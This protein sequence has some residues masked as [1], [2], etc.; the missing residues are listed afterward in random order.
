MNIDPAATYETCARAAKA[1]LAA[2]YPQGEAA[3]MVRIIFEQ[4][5][6]YSP[7][8]MIVNGQKPVS[9]FIQGEVSSTVDRLLAGE[10]IQYIFGT[11]RFCGLDLKVTPAVLIP[12]PETEELVDM[13][14]DR[15]GSDSDLSVLDVG[16][17]SGCIAVSL[18]RR[19][20]FPTVEAVDISAAALAVAR[21]NAEALKVRVNFSEAD[22][23]HLPAPAAPI[24]DIIVSNPPYIAES[25]RA[26]MDDN[27]L[28]HEPP[29][30][31]FVPDND[32]LRFYTA[33]SRYALK[34][35]RPGGTLWFEINPLFAAQMQS[36]L[37]GLGFD[38]VA[39]SA[40]AQGKQRFA[41]ATQPS[42]P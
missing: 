29:T 1:A 4:L 12:R 28:L 30:A 32:P 15:Y 2:R 17:G 26:S 24:Y 9:E 5:K 21:E 13:I 14:V 6:G 31:L 41:V 33:I 34:A 42:W 40:D 8:D 36:M 22:A 25:E 20:K 39:L 23:L 3:M 16:T 38:N 37:T 35:L 11:A 10:P 18:A 7:T 27:V 19:L